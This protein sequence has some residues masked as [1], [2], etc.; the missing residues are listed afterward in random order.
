MKVMRPTEMM[1]VVSHAVVAAA[2]EMLDI[3]EGWLWNESGVA[4]RFFGSDDSDDDG[5]AIAAVAGAADG[6]YVDR[7]AD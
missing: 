5:D 2:D 6:Y 3:V 1:V 7:A 4:D